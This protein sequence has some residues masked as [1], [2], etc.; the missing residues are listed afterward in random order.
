MKARRDERPKKASPILVYDRATGRREREVVLGEG[1][2]RF[3]YETAPG[4]LLGKGL[5]TRRCISRLYGLW[6]DTRLSARKTHRV[7][8]LL[9]ID[10]SEAEC[11]PGGFRS[12]NAFF[13]RALKS[14][15]RPIAAAPDTVIAACDARLFAL[16]RL[17]RDRPLQVK[18]QAF[19][20]ET[21]L[22]DAALADRYAGGTGF[23]YRLCPADYHRFH[24]PEA[25]VPGTAMPLGKGLHSVNPIALRSGIRILDANLRHRTLVEAGERAGTL[26]MV[27]VGA[28]FVGSIV[29][30]F[31]PGTP[32]P[33]GGEKGLFRFG[34]STVIVLYEPGKVRVDE[35]ILS[36]SGEG[37]ETRVR[38]G[39]QVGRYR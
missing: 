22:G 20:L 29:Q 27:E 9:S 24:F 35:D 15:V 39:E 10:L 32:V 16:H 36:Q 14:G 19:M 17:C 30:T 7:A 38:L 11:P 33:R 3:L 28:L 37:V 21:L 23:I 4:R 31:V 34:G 8:R 5:L 6:Q 26:C 1:G 13:S 18:G 12:F 25:G 2:L